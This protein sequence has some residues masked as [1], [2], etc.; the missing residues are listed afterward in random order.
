MSKCFWH[1]CWLHHWNTLM[2][3]KK[4]LILQNIKE[5]LT[6]KTY[7]VIK[8]TSQ[9]LIVVSYIRSFLCYIHKL[10]CPYDARYSSSTE[11]QM[12][13][14][15]NFSLSW[16]T[17]RNVNRLPTVEVI[18]DRVYS[19]HSTRQFKQLF[20]LTKFKQLVKRTNCQLLIKLHQWVST[21]QNVFQNGPSLTVKRRN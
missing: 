16:K 5:N 12:I 18:S 14:Q 7:A 21:K 8:F 4:Q 20:T 6:F 15:V 19:L 10:L 2:L 1:C 13:F 17:S 11:L 3:R 9:Q